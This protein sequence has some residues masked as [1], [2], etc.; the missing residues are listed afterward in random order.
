MEKRLS[1]SEA[2]RRLTV[3]VGREIRPREITLLFY[4]RVLSDRLAPIENGRRRIDHSLL[5]TIAD[6]LRGKKASSVEAAPCK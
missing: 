5:P 3:N 2:A 1:V 4:D 6:A